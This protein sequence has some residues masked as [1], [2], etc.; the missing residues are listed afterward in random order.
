MG[1]ASAGHDRGQLV[2]GFD[3]LNTKVRL[4]MLF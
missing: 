4:L 2:D 3:L 1:K